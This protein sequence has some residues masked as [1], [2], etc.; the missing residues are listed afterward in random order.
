MT[1]D[2]INEYL[3]RKSKFKHSYHFHLNN[4]NSSILEEKKP[5]YCCVLK[6]NLVEYNDINEILKFELS[7]LIFRKLISAKACVFF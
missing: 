1:H 5:N 7:S 4:W 6:T 2:K 3:Y